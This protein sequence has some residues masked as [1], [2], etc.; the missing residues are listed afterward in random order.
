MGDSDQRHD[1]AEALQTIKEAH[2]TGG[3]KMGV[4]EQIE[5]ITRPLY[6]GP[7]ALIPRGK[8]GP[9]TKRTQYDLALERRKG[10]FQRL[11]RL[12]NLRSGSGYRLTEEII[13]I[14]E[15][16]RSEG[17]RK[18]RITSGVSAELKRRRLSVPVDS[19]IRKILNARAQKK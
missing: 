10:P 8:R 2:A 12:P 6:L 15:Q 17:M 4:D 13:A 5:F 1:E 14:A 3:Q 18:N 16:C 11:V 9:K 19:S 7:P